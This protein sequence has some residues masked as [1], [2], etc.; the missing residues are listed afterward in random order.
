MP[1]AVQ[2]LREPIGHMPGRVQPRV[3]PRH[4]SQ[5]LLERQRRDAA[6][7]VRP[8][9][10]RPV[11]RDRILDREVHSALNR[12]LRWTVPCVALGPMGYVYFWL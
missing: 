12:I 1:A 2:L 10:A 5:L 6:H 9:I 11:M 4:T 7:H 3:L 8:R